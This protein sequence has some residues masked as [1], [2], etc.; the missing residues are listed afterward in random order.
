MVSLSI[1]HAANP[2]RPVPAGFNL[3]EL[4]LPGV[5][6]AFHRDSRLFTWHNF[7]LSVD[8][9]LKWWE[10]QRAQ[11]SAPARRGEGEELDGGAPARTPT[12]WA[13]FIRR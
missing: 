6:P 3:D 4:W 12:A 5:S 1:V 11:G 7:F 8:E 2:R 10:R 13:R 9:L